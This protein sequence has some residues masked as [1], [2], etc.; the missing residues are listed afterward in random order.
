MQAEQA[1]CLIQLENEYAS[2]NKFLA[3]AEFE[4]AISKELAERNF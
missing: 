1:K 3:Q 2:L 4:K